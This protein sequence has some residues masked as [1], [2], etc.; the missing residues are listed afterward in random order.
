MCP[1]RLWK[2]SLWGA[3]HWLLALTHMSYL[4]SCASCSTIS[5]TFMAPH[6]CASPFYTKKS[7]VSRFFPK[8]A[9]KYHHQFSS[10][11]NREVVKKRYDPG[12]LSPDYR[13][14]GQAI[15]SLISIT[16]FFSGA[17]SPLDSSISIP[18]NLSI[19]FALVSS[20]KWT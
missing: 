10:I 2:H 14:Y 18:L 11:H 7:Q 3:H 5:L 1:H 19:S 13:G 15:R 6:S 16:V 9:T 17:A 12:S 4:K 8:G 20:N